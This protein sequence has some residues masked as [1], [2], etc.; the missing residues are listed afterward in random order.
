MPDAN[1]C[2]PPIEGIARCG[3]RDTKCANESIVWQSN[4]VVESRL[5]QFKIELVARIAPGSTRHGTRV[6]GTGKH[7]VISASWSGTLVRR[8]LYT[9]G[10]E[11]KVQ[12]DAQAR[13]HASNESRQQL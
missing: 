8:L 4:S 2:R 10:V 1:L 3:R 6:E 9:G 11:G 7:G 12:L 13:S 5:T